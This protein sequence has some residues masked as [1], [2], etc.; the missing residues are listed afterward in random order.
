[1]YKFLWL[2]VAA[3]L[4]AGCQQA[5]LTCQS[6]THSI[7]QIQGQG[8]ES[9]LLGKTVTIQGMV[10]GVVYPD[11]PLPGLMLQSLTPD[12]D[13]LTSG[14]IFVA[15][16]NAQQYQSGQ[17]LQL[18]GTVAEVEQL[19]SLIDATVLDTCGSGETKPVSLTL[20]LPPELS[21]E[22]YEGM[23]LRIEQP[24][25]VTDSFNLGRYGEL[26]LADQRL[27]VPTQM[28]APGAAA[29]QR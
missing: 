20:P 10:L 11:G 9:P 29:Q 12:Q 17:I 8:E 23:W 25:V 26:M 19:T 16:A 4:A 14:A 13:P 5:P 28:V 3:A 7:A 18:S 22:A 15:L 2:V 21:W 27:M 1:M 24:L 6:V